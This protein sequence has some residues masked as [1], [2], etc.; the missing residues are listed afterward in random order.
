MIVSLQSVRRFPD[1]SF[2][3]YKID[4][5]MSLQSQYLILWSDPRLIWLFIFETIQIGDGCVLTDRAEKVSVS[6][7]IWWRRKVDPSKHCDILDFKTFLAA[8]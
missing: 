4:S 8:D 3:A 1:L 5:N 6:L 2:S 7:C